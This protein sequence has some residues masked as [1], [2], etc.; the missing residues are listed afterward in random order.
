MK[1]IFLAS[2]RSSATVDPL[3]SAVLK[4]SLYISKFLKDVV[5]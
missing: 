4:N 1:M 2:V 5:D 3:L